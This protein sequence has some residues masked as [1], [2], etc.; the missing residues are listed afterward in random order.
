MRTIEDVDRL[1]R[2]LIAFCR[3]NGRH[4]DQKSP[5]EQQADDLAAILM[6][7]LE[8]LHLQLAEGGD[9]G[10]RPQNEQEE[11]SSVLTDL[12]MLAQSGALHKVLGRGGAGELLNAMRTVQSAGDAELA[13]GLDAIDQGN[14]L[15][16]RGESQARMALLRE[17]GDL[18]DKKL[19]G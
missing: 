2:E 9:D 4:H 11:L 14:Y 8:M 6:M 7:K 3:T 18:L 19:K 16:S 1:R 12:A 13:Q 5:L 17:K 15:R 10:H